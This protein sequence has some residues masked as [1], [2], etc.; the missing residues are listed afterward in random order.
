MSMKKRNF[1]KFILKFYAN[2]RIFDY[3]YSFDAFK[4]SDFCSNFVDS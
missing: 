4:N 3:N 2:L 1:L